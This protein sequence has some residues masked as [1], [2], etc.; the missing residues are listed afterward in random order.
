MTELRIPSATYRIQFSL[1]FRLPDALD[2]V[3]YLNELGISELYASP[4]FK[5]RKGSSHG[6]DVADV[7]RV[8]SELGTEEEFDELV[9][10]LKSYSMGLLLDIVPNH[11]AA[12]HENAWWMDVLENGLSSE[13]ANFFDIDWHPA[14]TKAAF[15]QENKVLLPVLGDLYGNVLENQQLVLKLEEKG[16]R[17]RYFERQFPID[18]KS[19][20]S[21]IEQI[22]KVLQGASE[23]DAEIL[24]SVAGILG[25]IDRMPSGASLSP[26]DKRLRRTSARKINEDLWQ[27]YVSNA[28]A[29]QAVDE[30]IRHWNGTKGESQ[31]FDHLDHLLSVQSYRLAHW[32]IG[33]EEINYRRFF[34]INDLVG[35]RVEDPHV[36]EERHR[37]IFSMVRSGKVTGLRIDHIDGLYDPLGY[38]QQ[39]QQGVALGE[40]QPGDRNIY[41]VV[42][43]I[44][45]ERES[46]PEDWPV[47]GTT[48][49]DFVNAVNATFI[50]PEGLSNLESAYARFTKNTMPFAGAS[51]AGNKLVISQLFAGE[52]QSLTRA[53]AGLAAQDR[54][55]RDLPLHELVHLLVEV[56]ACLPV[57][58]TYMRA[59]TI[60]PRDRVFV[61]RALQRARER[62]PAGNISD[63][64]LVFLRQVLLLEPPAFAENR[65]EAYLRFAMRW[66]QLTGPVMA[67]G[68]EDTAS[69]VH[70]SL[71]SLNEVGEDPL[72]ESL[73]L[74][75]EAFHLFNQERQ[76]AW[77]HTL[78]ATSTHDTKRGEDVR[79]RINV[80]SEFSARWEAALIRWSRWNQS[81]KKTIGDHLAPSSSEEVLLYQTLLGAWPLQNEQFTEFKERIKEFMIKAAREAKVFTN[82]IEPNPSHEAALQDFVETVLRAD[83]RNRFVEDLT[84]FQK[85]VAFYGALSS[86]SQVLLKICSPG[87][88]DFYQGEELWDFNLVDP[89]N[90]RPVDFVTRVALLDELKAAEQRDASALLADLVEHWQ[91][92]R[93][94]LY[95]TWKAARFRREYKKLFEEGSYVPLLT[96]G[97]IA[98]TICAFA[99]RVQKE[100][101]VS[102]A[103]RFFTHLVDPGQP[104][105]GRDVWGSSALPLPR[106]APL[107]WK[108]VLTGGVVK[109]KGAA[110]QQNRLSLASVFESFPVALLH[111]NSKGSPLAAQSS[112][113]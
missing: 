6:Y 81:R 98:S 79:A 83:G 36:F 22:L 85:D 12:T 54:Q 99:R 48:G 25:E 30:V 65:R 42:E 59:G 43:K 47:A 14:P 78:N 56:T 23:T 7:Q 91:D 44:L 31:S 19:C 112:D 60:S 110:G 9:L 34:D 32:K 53:L 109:A 26:E 50:D 108:N 16:F 101:V 106:G 40:S 75:V 52:I 17:I 21:L 39:L 82:W 57:Y 61:E 29:H 92:G 55:A 105:F 80:L 33:S 4:S 94:K 107:I 27:G 24:T 87:V 8:N 45:G 15:L 93:I 76:E 71:I 37:R 74:E 113:T 28:G 88:P 89:D 66:Q 97:R 111:A 62:T 1:K 90:R 18:P 35:L 41:V 46:L 104:P 10:K 20:R 86:L 103:P 84:R 11:M 69:Y 49:Y 70:N 5:A 58:R 96:T 73:P 3:P 72:R 77:P 64:A 2:L 100:W 38:L 102:V 51:Y 13:F 63:A 67:K 95:L 68:L